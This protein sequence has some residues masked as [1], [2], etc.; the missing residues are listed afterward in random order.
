MPEG[1]AF[2]AS[3]ARRVTEFGG[4][5]SAEAEKG[6]QFSGRVF[7]GKPSVIFVEKVGGV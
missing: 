3:A 2:S 7:R 1:L 6:P 4:R 5:V